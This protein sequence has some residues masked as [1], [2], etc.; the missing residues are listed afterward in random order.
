LIRCKERILN[1]ITQ[2]CKNLQTDLKKGDLVAVLRT[3]PMYWSD[4][5]YYSNKLSYLKKQAEEAWGWELRLTGYAHEFGKSK[6]LDKNKKDYSS[7]YGYGH[8]DKKDYGTDSGYGHKDKKDY[9]SDYGYSHKV[10]R[11]GAHAGVGVLGRVKGF[12]GGYDLDFLFSDPDALHK[13]SSIID[14]VTKHVSQSLMF[15]LS[16]PEGSLEAMKN[17]AKDFPKIVAFVQSSYNQ[18]CDASREFSSA[19]KKKDPEM[20]TKL[21]QALQHS[22][23]CFIAHQKLFETGLENKNI[24]QV[25]QIMDATQDLE[26]MNLYSTLEAYVETEFCAHF[27]PDIHEFAQKCLL[28]KNMRNALGKQVLEWKS[29]VKKHFQTDDPRTVSPIATERD[30]FYVDL[31]QSFHQLMHIKRFPGHIDASTLDLGKIEEECRNHFRDQISTLEKTLE[32]LLLNIP[33]QDMSVY[34]QEFNKWHGNLRSIFGNFDDTSVSTAAKTAQDTIDRKFK[35]KLHEMEDSA[36]A[37]ISD[38]DTDQCSKDL[39]GNFVD[40]LIKIKSISSQIPNY[41]KDVNAAIDKIMNDIKSLKNGVILISQIC[42]I[43]NA[44]ENSAISHELISD[45]NVFQGYALELRNKKTLTFTVD[46]VLGLTE[47]YRGSKEC[48]LKGDDINPDLLKYHYNLFD[49]EYWKLVEKGLIRAETEVVLKDLVYKAKTIPRESG[50]MYQTTARKLMACVFAYWTLDHYQKS[51]I[52][53]EESSSKNYLLQPHAAQV[54]GIFRLLGIE[55][56]ECTLHKD[57]CESDAKRLPVPVET[58]LPPSPPPPEKGLFLK[59]EHNFKADDS[60]DALLTTHNSTG[61]EKSLDSSGLLVDTDMVEMPVDKTCSNSLLKPLPISLPNHLVE[62]LTGEGKSVTLAVTACVLALLGFDVSC[63][64]YSEYLS[65]RDYDSFQPVFKAFDIHEH[66]SYGTFN[67]L[68]EDFI[69]LQGDVRDIVAAIISGGQH[70]KQI[71][72]LSGRPAALLID[73]VDVFFNKDFYGNVYRPLLSLKHKS[74]SSLIRH[75]WNT[76]SQPTERTFTAIKSSAVYISCLEFLSGWAELLEECVK[77]M[78]N[79]LNTYESQ[80]YVVEHDKIGYKDQDTISYNI[81]YGYKTLFA[82][83]KEWEDGNIT[84][85]TLESKTALL[86]SCGN[87]SYAEIPKCYAFV[88]GVTGTLNT[89]SPPE[90]KLLEDAYDIRRKTFV[91]SVYGKNQ[92]NFTADSTTDCIIDSRASF[93]INLTNEIKYR[94]QSISTNNYQR[95]V[96]VF[97]E[98]TKK[99]KEFLNSEPMKLIKSEQKVRILTEQTFPVDREGIIAYAV[100]SGGITLLG[101]EFGR[102]TDFICHDDRLIQSGGIHVI[103][104]FV[105]EEISEETQ[106]KGRTARQGNKG[107][108]SMVLIDTELE[109]YG[110]SL[111]EIN[112]MKS[113][114]K[115]YSRI[116]Q[117]RCQ[118]FEASYPENMRYV[119]EIKEDHNKSTCFLDQ[120][121]AHKQGSENHVKSFL[122]RQNKAPAGGVFRTLILMDATGSMSGVI[123][124]SKHTVKTMF[125]RMHSVIEAK[126]GTATL[127]IQFACYRNYDCSLEMLLQVSPWE[128]NPDNLRKFMDSISAYGGTH[129]EEAIEIALFHAV[130]EHDARPIDQVILIGDAAPNTREQVAAGRARAPYLVQSRFKVPTFYTEQLAELRKRGIPVHAYFVYPSAR[131]SFRGISSL[132]APG[133]RSEELLINSPQGHEQLT[134]LIAEEILRKV[135][136]DE[137]VSDYRHMFAKGYL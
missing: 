83:F 130:S 134:N 43:L 102:G 58:S 91:P 113:T 34:C 38:S 14:E 9:S 10:Y 22:A 106:I 92:L 2:S 67:R 40:E 112:E 48:P 133:G 121:M 117:K 70:P 37:V 97:F 42:L 17:L 4:W 135:G 51:A 66:I 49:Q 1:N 31:S 39:L 80:E 116:N 111:A 82:Y 76:R 56:D 65:K 100:N 13:C 33:S 77:T 27:T 26:A 125:E 28:Y 124:K 107:S 15:V 29:T 44:H 71:K 18:K 41:K 23:A 98:T 128:T 89:L 87:F 32:D 118:F 103:Q 81:S 25:A 53:S 131:E 132:A 93:H 136:G 110:I 47:D 52:L 68:C 24:S 54:I 74:I 126:G 16:I 78:L 55:N 120:I 105:S 8:K 57:F 72:T 85:S 123:T 79:D 21:V 46:H 129:W 108:F 12:L 101:R 5:M 137:L 36:F 45:T 30:E 88:M 96:L 95:A 7:D 119:D 86:I 99:L 127:E 115:L 63:A 75:I 114:G 62:I 60:T 109:K 20:E 94:L 61:I 3:F 59:E 90:K 35:L 122:L 69:N 104:T 84:P 6:S 11:T 64:C 50:E 73:E 19:V